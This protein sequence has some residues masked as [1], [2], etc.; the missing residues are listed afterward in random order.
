[1]LE[2][3]IE[4]IDGYYSEILSK[5]SM[6]GLRQTAEQGFHTGGRPPY[7]YKIVLKAVDNKNRKIWEIEPKEAEAVT[8]IYKMHTEGFTYDEIIN[9]LEEQGHKPRIAQS[10]S[11]SGVSQIL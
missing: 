8:L 1:M 3:M 6:R 7:G 9:K 5:E 10:W 2:G 4:L 11:R